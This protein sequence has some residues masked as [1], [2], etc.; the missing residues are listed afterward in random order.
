MLI[1]LIY[2]IKAPD[3]SLA[4]IAPRNLAKFIVKALISF[5]RAE[6]NSHNDF[7][8][9]FLVSFSFTNFAILPYLY[10]LQLLE[11][12]WNVIFY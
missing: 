12:G 4:L 7:C 10:I 5:F 1:G 2:P 11:F 9:I 3:L 6:L 8:H